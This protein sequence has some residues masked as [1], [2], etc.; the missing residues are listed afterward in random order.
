MPYSIVSTSTT[1]CHVL[2]ALW[3]VLKTF[4][5]FAWWGIFA[6]WGVFTWWGAFEMFAF[7]GPM[8]WIQINNWR[9]CLLPP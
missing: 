5:F 6:P 1:P 8:G 9:L 4:D 3:S 2:L 7:W